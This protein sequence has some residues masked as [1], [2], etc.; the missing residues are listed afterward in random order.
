MKYIFASLIMA[1]AFYLL[2]H[3]TRILF[4]LGMTVIGGIIYFISIMAID[5]EARKLVLTIWK[6][7]KRKAS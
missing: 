4:T 6:E 3:P 7:I 2:P 5:K 1:T